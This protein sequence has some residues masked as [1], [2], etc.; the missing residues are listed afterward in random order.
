MVFKKK[1][2]KAPEMKENPFTNSYLHHLRIHQN[3]IETDRA[4]KTNDLQG[5]FQGLV[6][7]YKLI[8]FKLGDE[9]DK[10]LKGKIEK[11][12]KE[13]K[14][15]KRDEATLSLH[16][17]EIDEIKL[18]HKY[19]LIFPRFEINSGYTKIEKRYG[20]VDFGY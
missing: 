5:W 7:G 8:V 16:E 12:R 4:Y 6:V 2:D 19:E 17:I 9:E 20:D 15:N 11:A 18:R 1:E 13:I 10:A 3:C 14:E